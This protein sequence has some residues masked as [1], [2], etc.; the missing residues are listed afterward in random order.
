[1]ELLDFLV[2]EAFITDLRATTKEEA[3]REIVRSVQDARYLAGVDTQILVD[4]FMAR[5]AL[6]S[7][8]FRGVACP[9][10]G[11][12]KVNRPFGTVALSRSG[13]EFN[14]ADGNP[15]YVVFL[16]FHVPDQFSGRPVKPGDIY[17][18]FYA[19]ASLLKDEGRIE[20]LRLSQ[21][22]AE[23]S[24]VLVNLSADFPDARVITA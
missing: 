11:H 17:D 13:V 19:I 9:H 3:I 12:Q 6:S 8:A 22:R 1:M 5:E 2:R 7:T 24:N 4:S 15:V 21:T 10:G 16:L 23:I 20:R 18:A 14:S